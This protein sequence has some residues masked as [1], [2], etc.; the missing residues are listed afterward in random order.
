[1]SQ[2]LILKLTLVEEYIQL[3]NYY[4]NLV[5]TSMFL[6]LTAVTITDIIG[7]VRCK[8]NENNPNKILILSY[9]SCNNNVI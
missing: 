1:M 6:L 7:F 2:Q 9:L 4:E 3:V 8:V 5:V